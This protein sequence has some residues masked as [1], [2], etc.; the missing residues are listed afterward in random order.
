[1]WGQSED[2]AM[3]DRVQYI[4]QLG[5]VL[6]TGLIAGTF[7]AFSSFIMSALERL[8]PAQGVAAMQAINITVINPVFM[9]V[10]FGTA[11]LASYC[12]FAAFRSGA[13]P[14]AVAAALLYVI[15]A[16]GVT[17]ICNVPLNN[18]L[19]SLQSLAGDGEK[20]WARYLSDWTFWNSVR[21]IAAAAA[22]TAFAIAL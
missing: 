20:I 15:G 16:I 1:M 14:S 21:G 13:N 3:P 17:M 5:C 6:G 8:P 12:G 2:Q 18:E 4:M 10:L 9:G 22:C 11:I 7:L 19:A